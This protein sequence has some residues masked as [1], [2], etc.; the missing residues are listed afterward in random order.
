MG[1]PSMGG[2]ST[3]QQ[4]I[5]PFFVPEHLSIPQPVK[6]LLQHVVGSNVEAGA[7]KD[8]HGGG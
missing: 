7:R 3:P 4:A 1:G 8:T 6:Q 5:D 2:P